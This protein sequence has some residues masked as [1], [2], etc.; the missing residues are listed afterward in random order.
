MAEGLE[1]YH[2]SDLQKEK[3]TAK[4][5][6]KKKR[7][8]EKARK[9][10]K[11]KLKAFEAHWQDPQWQRTLQN[12]FGAEYDRMIHEKVDELDGVGA[13]LSLFPEL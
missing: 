11:S 10:E 12:W 5:E 2:A 8:A 4:R 9:Q 1:V 7:E 13:Q 6:A 3:V